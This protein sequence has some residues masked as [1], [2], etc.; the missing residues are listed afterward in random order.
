LTR[1]ERVESENNMLQ[2]KVVDLKDRIVE[3]EFENHSKT[4]V[5]IEIKN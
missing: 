1:W 2:S 4:Q 5:V 3:M